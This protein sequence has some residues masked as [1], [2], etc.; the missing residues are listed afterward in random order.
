MYEL[1][2]VQQMLSFYFFVFIFT[3]IF[4]ENFFK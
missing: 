3:S 4:L 2:V 1:I